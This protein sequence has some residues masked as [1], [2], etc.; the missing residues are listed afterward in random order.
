MRPSEQAFGKIQP[1]TK[2]NDHGFTVLDEDELKAIIGAG[3]NIQ[4]LQAEIERLTKKIKN[5]E[6]VF[7]AKLIEAEEL[8][9]PI[10]EN[11]MTKPEIPFIY[12]P[13]REKLIREHIDRLKKVTRS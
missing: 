3:N 11:L 12:W 9:M 4:A 13:D 5:V 7:R 6:E 1:Q 2:L 8:I 10:L